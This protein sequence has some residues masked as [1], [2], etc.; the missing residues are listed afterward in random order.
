V[1]LVSL[2]VEYGVRRRGGGRGRGQRRRR[3]AG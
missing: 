1:P 2:R 3:T